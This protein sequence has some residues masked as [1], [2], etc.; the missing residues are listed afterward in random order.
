MEKREKRIHHLNEVATEVTHAVGKQACGREREG[1]FIE[2]VRKSEAAEK[3]TGWF[4][5]AP[6][7]KMREK[8]KS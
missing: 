8:R 2:R 1:S 5:P 6:K 4:R 3:H 7:R